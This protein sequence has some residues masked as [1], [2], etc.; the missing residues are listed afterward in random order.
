MQRF[1]VP[2]TMRKTFAIVAAADA[3]DAFPFIRPA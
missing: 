1:A 3:R 2:A